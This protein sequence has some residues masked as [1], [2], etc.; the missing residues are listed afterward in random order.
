MT[1]AAFLA[2]SA[3]ARTPIARTTV[4]RTAISGATTSA[5]APTAPRPL[6]IFRSAFVRSLVRLLESSFIEG[7]AFGRVFEFV[8]AGAIVGRTLGLA[9]VA[10]FLRRS[11]GSPDPSVL[12]AS[13]RTGSSSSTSS[14]RRTSALFIGR[15]AEPA[16]ASSPSSN[17]S[18]LCA[19]FAILETAGAVLFGGPAARPTRREIAR[20]VRGVPRRGRARSLRKCCSYRAAR[21]QNRRPHPNRAEPTWRILIEVAAA[22]RAR[23]DV[24]RLDALPV[25]AV[26]AASLAARA[27]GPLAALGATTARIAVRPR[28]GD[29][30][31]DAAVVLRGCVSSAGSSLAGHL[32]RSVVLVP[33][34]Q[35][36]T[37]HHRIARGGVRPNHDGRGRVRLGL[38]VR[39]HLDLRP[40][41]GDVLDRRDGS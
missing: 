24:P 11:Q 40:R 10:Q 22:F 33:Q 6:R 39:R 14:A 35:N 25:V 19:F 38:L 17:S 4:A 27:A 26:R 41:R 32:L 5:T 30:A 37:H 9:L 29:R 20:A 16:S 34:P 3:I 13:S 12:R 8:I 31:S 7:R 23:V 21:L 15:S 36:D 2:R 18:D 1:G 28:I